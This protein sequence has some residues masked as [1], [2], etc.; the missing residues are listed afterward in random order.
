MFHSY[1]DHVAVFL[2]NGDGTFNEPVTYSSTYDSFLGSLDDLNGDGALDLILVRQ[3]NPRLGILFNDG[4][5]T[6]GTAQNHSIDDGGHLCAADIDGDGDLD[7]LVRT[8]SEDVLLVMLNLLNVGDGSFGPPTVYATSGGSGEPRSL[9]LIDLDADS[10]PDLA[11]AY[12]SISSESNHVDILFNSGDGTFAPPVVY[13]TGLQYSGVT[14]EDLDRDGLPDLSVTSS[15]SLMVMC[16]FGDGSFDEP[17]YFA[18]AWHDTLADVDGD[19]DL[20]RVGDFATG[21][22][23]T[24]SNACPFGDLN[25]DGSVDVADLMIVLAEW[26]PCPPPPATCPADLNGDGAVNVPDLLI[27]LANW[28]A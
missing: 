21:I 12:G 16:G 9:A 8:W 28:S 23:V 2:G 24:F 7:L 3:T 18:R 14:I 4:S 1:T 15:H 25:G 17:Q 6:F 20:D 26:G 11:V 10:D 22:M 27:I 19:L 5:G 13:A